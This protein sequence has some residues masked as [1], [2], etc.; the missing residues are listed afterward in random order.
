M[1]SNKMSDPEYKQF[2]KSMEVLVPLLFRDITLPPEKRPLALLESLEKTS[3]A[4]AKKGLEMAMS[5]ILEMTGHWSAAAIAQLDLALQSAGAPS[6]AELRLR[7]SKKL[8]AI[9]KRGV[10]RNQPEYELVKSVLNGAL[11]TQ[12]SN[13]DLQQLFDSYEGY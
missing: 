4:S 5:D 2:K 11:S 13:A 9:I 1:T 8:A 10:I 7:F 3:P 12:I 6:V